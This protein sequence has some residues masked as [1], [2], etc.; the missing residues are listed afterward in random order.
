[1]IDALIALLTPLCAE[2][3]EQGSMAPHAQYPRR[4]FT[5]W[6]P[7]TEDHKHYDNATHGCKWTM[8]VNFYSTNR[9]DVS[10]TLEA[11]METLRQAGWIISGKGHAVA[12]DTKT[13]TGRGFTATYL[14][15]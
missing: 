6:N 9:A 2:I 14:E 15:L 3:I 7:D 10:S 4:F 5:F 1:M 11:A 12:S 8:E 13:H